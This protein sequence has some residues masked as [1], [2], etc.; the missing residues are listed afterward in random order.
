[1]LKQSDK[2]NILKICYA[3]LCAVFSFFWQKPFN[4]LTKFKGD[5][6]LLKL[7]LWELQEFVRANVKFQVELHKSIR[8]T[9]SLEY[10]NI[11]STELKFA[12]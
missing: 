11:F 8:L 6:V 4:N 1:M 9:I 3:M 7:K 2:I 5:F 12:L 10:P